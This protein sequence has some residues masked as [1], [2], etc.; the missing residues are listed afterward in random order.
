[1]IDSGKLRHRI[2]FQQY[3][4]T[5]DQYGDVRD[6]E[7]E[8][9]VTVKT[10]WAGIYPV[11]GREFY[12]AEQNQSEVTHNIYCRYFDGISPAMRILHKGKIY[13]IISVLDWELRHQ[14]CQI[15]AKELL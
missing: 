12:E 5:V 11:A 6:D 4:G 9:W 8:N 10:V 14:S 2:S 1:M 7:D 13:Q 3:D 15:K